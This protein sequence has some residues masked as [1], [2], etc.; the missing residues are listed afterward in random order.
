[1]SNVTVELRNIAGTEAALGWA[2]AHTVAQNSSSGSDNV[3][4]MMIGALVNQVVTSMYDP[5]YG[6]AY[7]LNYQ[8]FC[9]DRVGLLTGHRHPEYEKLHAQRLKDYQEWKAKQQGGQQ[10]ASQPT[11]DSKPAK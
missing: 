6:L 9:N 11:T 8:L 2:G 1:M 7:N 5:S 3:I 4:G 10:P